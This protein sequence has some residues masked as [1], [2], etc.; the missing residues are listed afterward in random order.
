MSSSRRPD[1]RHGAASV[2]QNARLAAMSGMTAVY[3]RREPSLNLT[4]SLDVDNL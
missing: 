2:L 4:S 1:G 3:R